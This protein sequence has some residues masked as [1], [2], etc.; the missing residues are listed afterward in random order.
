MTHV[1]K[2]LLRVFL[3]HSSGDKP[4]VR[5]LSARL[6]EDGFKPWLDETDIVGGNNWEHAIEDAVRNSDIVIVCLSPES[7]SKRGVLQ[8]E[9]RYI[10]DV[11]DEEPLESTFVIPLKLREC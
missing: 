10:L 3:C 7:I 8:K 4:E 9:L 5:E 6:L 11:A 2:R 1:E